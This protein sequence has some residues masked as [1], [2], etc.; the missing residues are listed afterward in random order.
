M[1]VCIFEREVWAYKVLKLK[2]EQQQIH[3]FLLLTY[4]L[5]TAISHMRETKKVAS[6]G[7]NK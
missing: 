4:K 7:I 6:Y 3:A 1:S 5:N 2:K